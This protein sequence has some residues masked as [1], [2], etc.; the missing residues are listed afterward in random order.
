MKEFR[1][2]VVHCRRAPF[3]VLIDRTTPWGNPFSHLE[4]SRGQFKVRS[5]EEAIEK[6]EEWI[7]SQPDLV[8]R[9]K[10]ELKGK[11]L[12]CWCKPLPCHGDVLARI[13]NGWR[14]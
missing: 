2:L 1:S 7:K 6:F 4:K 3:D 5:R 12:G 11:V 8:A 10:K 14:K 9:A 13:A